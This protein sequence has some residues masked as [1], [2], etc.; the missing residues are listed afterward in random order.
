MAG[1]NSSI[2]KPAVAI[3]AI[4][5]A[6]VVYVGVIIVGQMPSKL[7]TEKLGPSP[8]AC[9]G[10]ACA[11][12]DLPELAVIALVICVLVVAIGRISYHIGEAKGDD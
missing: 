11:L 1:S 6:I 3:V 5:F 9:Y 4:T 12:R 10:L 2:D 7:D 8:E